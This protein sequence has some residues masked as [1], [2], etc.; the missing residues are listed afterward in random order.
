MSATP[1]MAATIQPQGVLLVL[2]LWFEEATA[3][4]ATAAPAAAA[5]PLLV[6]VVVA[7]VV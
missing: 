3:A 4:P 1:R 5:L 6:V 7:L 2:S